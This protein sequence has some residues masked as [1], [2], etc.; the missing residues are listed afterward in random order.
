MHNNFL[1]RAQNISYIP[2][3]I[4]KFLNFQTAISGLHSLVISLRSIFAKLFLW[5]VCHSIAESLMNI[6]K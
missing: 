2:I 6:S 3:W 5:R 4:R 1:I